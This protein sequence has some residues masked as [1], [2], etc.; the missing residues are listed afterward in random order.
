M[1]RSRAESTAFAVWIPAFAGMTGRKIGND[2]AK[3]LE[4]Q[5]KKSGLTGLA[6]A[7]GGEEIGIDS[8]ATIPFTP[9]PAPP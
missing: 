1:P 5:G 9:I 4:R 2:E 6:S 8:A 3:N 7:N